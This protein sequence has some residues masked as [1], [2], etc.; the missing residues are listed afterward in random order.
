MISPDEIR[1]FVLELNGMKDNAIARGDEYAEAKHVFE[2]FA[3]LKKPTLSKEKNRIA[4]EYFKLEGKHLSE[5]R[6]ERLAYASDV[7]INWV[8]QM[9][10]G[11]K[12]KIKSHVKYTALKDQGDYLRT[13]ISLAKEVCKI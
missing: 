1:S 12:E 11:E 9:V 5:A 6:L 4:D 7:Y 10:D 8:E 2:R 3:E 13:I